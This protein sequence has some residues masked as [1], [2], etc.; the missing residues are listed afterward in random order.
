M[1]Y[2]VHYAV[3]LRYDAYSMPVNTVDLR[4]LSCRSILSVIKMRAR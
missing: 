3:V 4:C 1:N 2:I